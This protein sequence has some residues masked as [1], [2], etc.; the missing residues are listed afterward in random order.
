M[1]INIHT[2]SSI[3]IHA[4]YCSINDDKSSVDKWFGDLRLMIKN[5]FINCIFMYFHI[6]I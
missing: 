2:L 1:D 4:H 3:L 6:H 5:K